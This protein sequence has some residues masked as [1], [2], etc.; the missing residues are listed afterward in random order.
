M[1]NFEA[2][3]PNEVLTHLRFDV[4]MK[5][6]YASNLSSNFYQSMYIEHM[7]RWNRFSQGKPPIKHGFK[8]FDHAFRSIIDNTVDEPVPVNNEGHIANGAHRL[9]AALYRQR[10]INVRSTNIAENYPIYANYEYF[11]KKGMPKYMLGRTAL[12]YARLKSNTHMI[13]L[14]PIAHTRVDE[15]M[16]IIDEYS[17]IFYRSSEVLNY[18]GQLALMKEIYFVE[19][20]HKNNFSPLWKNN[21]IL[22]L[23]K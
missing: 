8:E 9:A 20:V 10:P 12:E 1:K 3:D 7:Q 17:N 14:F 18:E 13:C 2:R 4:V 6:L 22:I 5:Y 16:A 21:K 23:E 11:I 19:T 15:V